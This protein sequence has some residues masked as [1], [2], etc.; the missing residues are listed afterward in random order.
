MRRLALIGTITI[1]FAACTNTQSL[2]SP[3]GLGRLVGTWRG[4]MDNAGV[5]LQ[6]VF[7]V[8]Q[9]DAG[10]SVSID[11]PAQNAENLP[12]RTI[13]RERQNVRMEAPL[14]GA[15]YTA[16]LS[17]DATQMQGTWE[18]NGLNVALTLV[19]T[20]GDSGVDQPAASSRAAR[21]PQT[22]RPPFPYQSL[23]L[24]F[25]NE[26]EGISFGATVTYPSGEGP[27]PGVVLISGSG[28]QDRNHSLFGHQ[29]FAVLADALTRSG[30]AVL[31]YDDR[32]VGESGGAESLAGVTSE[33]FA[34]DVLSAYQRLS[35]LPYVDASRVGLAGLSEGG[36]IAPMIVEMSRRAPG[37]IAPPHFLVLLGAS[38]V[39]GDALMMAQSR[40]LLEA[41]G[42]GEEQIRSAAQAN[43]AVYDVA[44]SDLSD[45]QAAEAIRAI[46]ED[47]GLSDD[48]IAAQVAALT[49]AW[50]RSFLRY[51]PAPVLKELDQA[52]LALYG[53][54]DVQVP[55]QQNAPAMREALS[56]A[57]TERF[58]VEVIEGVNHLLQPANTGSPS[59]YGQ[60]ET[61]IAES[62]LTAI[63][64]WLSQNVTE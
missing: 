1:F 22:P 27:F 60:I 52:V 30:M 25:K 23:E 36:S 10:V 58:S 4:T 31:R 63:T 5:P 14:L 9:T 48:Q 39:P 59:E 51:N 34:R 8:R 35:S 55:P 3:E 18:Q 15:T 46:L 19:R 43:R 20:N 33:S 41:S 57:P 17:D 47:L 12:V 50:Y 44:L 64:S 37:S 24:T 40:A 38:A 26:Q 56:A 6:M 53:A 21:R 28:Q 2:D 49:S 16:E 62:V 54:L 11:V 29:T 13:T 42:A 7:H 45:E 61:T 32:G